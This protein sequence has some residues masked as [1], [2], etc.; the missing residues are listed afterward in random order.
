MFVQVPLRSPRT[1]GLTQDLALHRESG[2]F[3]GQG[4]QRDPHFPLGKKHRS[5]INFS[6]TIKP[7]EK[8]LPGTSI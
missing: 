5:R 8:S 7:C 1:R 4:V 6:H 3:P 2:N